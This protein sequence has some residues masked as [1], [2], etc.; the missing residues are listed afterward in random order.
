MK[1]RVRFAALP[2][3]TVTSSSMEIQVPAGTTVGELLDTLA[4][5]QPALKTYRRFVSAA[6][7]RAYVG[8]QTEL[9]EDDEVFYAPPVGGG[10]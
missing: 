9:H 7:N 6:V 8:M 1:V 10:Q 3:G 2:P 5:D 4:A